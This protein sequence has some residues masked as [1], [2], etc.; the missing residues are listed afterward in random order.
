MPTQHLRRSSGHAAEEGADLGCDA[1]GQWSIGKE[2]SL[3][4]VIGEMRLACILTWRRLVCYRYVELAV[5]PRRAA[6]T[7]R[8]KETRI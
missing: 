5:W 3:V 2:R 6:S 8:S 7:A 1:S 4:Q